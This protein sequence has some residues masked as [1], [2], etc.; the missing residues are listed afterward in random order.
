MSLN[1]QQQQDLLQLSQQLI[2]CQSVTP[3]DAGCMQIITPLLKNMGLQLN[4]LNQQG[5]SNIWAQQNSDAP[6]LVFAGHTDVV[7]AG[8]GWQQEPFAANIEADIL[9][10]RGAQDMK[11]ALA[12]MLIAAQAFLQEQ[13]Q[14][15]FNLAFLLTSD[16]EGPAEHGSKYV[17]QWLQQQGIKPQWCL[18][19]EPTSTTA[20]GD[21][22]KVGRRGSLNANITI[23]G[24]QGHIAYPEKASNP[25]HNALPALLAL[26]AEKWD[27]GNEHFQPTQ[28]QYANINA[29]N[30]TQNVIPGKL[31]I[32]GNFRFSPAS[33]ADEL[34]QRLENILKQQKLRYEIQWQLSGEPFYTPNS[35][36]LDS[37]IQAVQQSCNMQPQLSTNG[38]T[39]DGRFLATLGTE[40]IELGTLNNR[41]HQVDEQLAITEL[42]QLGNIYL[43][44][45]KELAINIKN[46]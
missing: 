45:L 28:F 32:H 40:V 30:G 24:Q 39:S 2:R 25:I 16:E 15:P 46:N 31:Q 43:A 10:G 35:L 33:S 20:S 37:A 26:S 36:L 14:P 19:G 41:I 44:T 42:M 13:P 3:D 11:T 34:K 4:E 17:T 6:I 5:V 29:G 9:H 23:H 1:S 7:P 12:A 8:P 27:S 21:T 22:I 38:G 18:V